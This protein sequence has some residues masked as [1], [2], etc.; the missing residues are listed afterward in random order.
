MTIWFGLAAWMAALAIVVVLAGGVR[1]GD[2]LRAR[3]LDP[4]LSG[5]D[6]ADFEERLAAPLTAARRT[7]G[8]RTR[9]ATG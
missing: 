2:R 6:A 9:R 8:R 1:R 3:A 7:P 5:S 4:R